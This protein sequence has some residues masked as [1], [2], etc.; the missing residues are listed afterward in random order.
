MSEGVTVVVPGHVTLFFSVHETDDPA[1]TGSRGAGLNL[2]ESVQ[3]TVRRGSGQSINGT[4]GTIAAVEGVL[5]TLDVTA[6][7]EIHT[8]LPLGT[9]FGVSGAAALGTALGA[10]RLFDCGHTRDDLV[11]LAHVAEVEAGTGLGD[12][13]AQARGG[14][15]MRLE[16]GAPPHARL[17]TIPESRPL[18]LY[19]MG[20]LSTPAVLEGDTTA[21]TRSGEDALDRLRRDPTLATAFAAGRTFASETGLLEPEVATVI[22]DVTAAGGS[23]AMGMLG[24]TVVALDHGLSRAGYAVT[25]TAVADRGARFAEDA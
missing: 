12:V 14:V 19:S 22:E 5:D 18:E 8:E 15:V 11:R 2:T 20:D 17:D 9:G 4:G 7:V 21:I 3:V 6:A 10:N 16:P 24:R 23:A 1:T 25:A 13:V